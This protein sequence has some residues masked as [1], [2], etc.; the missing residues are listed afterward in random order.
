MLSKNAFIAFVIAGVVLYSCGGSGGRGPAP[1]PKPEK[2][3]IRGT[4]AITGELVESARA[5]IGVF[6]PSSVEAL[7]FYE[8]PA[9][10]LASGSHS[11]QF[12]NLDFGEYRI[13]VVVNF[14]ES[15]GNKM[16]YI[17]APGT[18]RVTENNA[19]VNG[20]DFTAEIPP[21]PAG[22]GSISGVVT[23]VQGFPDLTP[24][25]GVYVGVS[26]GLDQASVGFDKIEPSEV[27]N[28]QASYSITDLEFGTYYVSIY[29]YN[30]A[31]HMPRFFGFYQGT[32][33]LSE[34]NPD[35]TGINFDADITE[36][37]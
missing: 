34:S 22:T 20:Y 13:A 16:E 29:V 10:D 2:G 14:G 4:V 5:F 8:I 6:L 26:L 17:Y 37:G 35:Q 31:T 30:V 21:A 33:T 36:L 18:V 3:T 11:Y 24:E 12:A 7:S 32:V 25:E 28:N 27:S 1:L 23:F 19:I 15:F 9:G